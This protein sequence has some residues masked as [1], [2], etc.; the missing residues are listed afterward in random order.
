MF[1][2]TQKESFLNGQFIIKQLDYELD[3]VIY[4]ILNHFFMQ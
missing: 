3:Q 2:K 4:A 1:S